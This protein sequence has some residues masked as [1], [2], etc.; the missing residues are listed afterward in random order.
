[1][2]ELTRVPFHDTTI[3]TTADGAYVALRPVCETL[4]LDA[5][6]QWQR[7]RRRSWATACMMHAVAAD[8][9][10][11]EMTFIDR[12]TFA[13]WLATI[14]TGRIK[15]ERSRALID[16]YQCEAA[17]A[18]DRYFN[19]GVAVNPRTEAK[20]LMELIALAKGAVSPDHLEAKA[21]IILARAMGEAP[22][23]EAQARPLYA[24]D[25]KIQQGAT[26]DEVRRYS[27]VFGKEVKKAYKSAHAGQVPG[28]YPYETPEGQ[29]RDVC[30]YTEADR[31]LMERVWREKFAH[32]LNHES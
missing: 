32:R 15:D 19:E 8:G 5:N 11:R 12:R 1:V 16:A 21:R 7:L 24:Q 17:D 26:R 13:M 2:K 9:K 27:S 18:L 10:K 23:I 29:I 31:P 14:D 30:A 6:G 28:K 3:Y 22:Q 20:E 4:G 25:F